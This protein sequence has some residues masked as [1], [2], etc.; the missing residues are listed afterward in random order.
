MTK[1]NKVVVQEGYKKKKIKRKRKKK[2]AI[3]PSGFSILKKNN[4]R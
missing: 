4:N 3:T 2:S 1:R